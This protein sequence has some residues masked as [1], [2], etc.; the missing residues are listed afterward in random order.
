EAP[1][2]FLVTLLDR[3]NFLG[4]ILTGR[5]Q[6]GVVKV[7]QS[8]H[9]L[10]EQGNVIETG[11]ASKLMSFRGLDRVPVD[12]ARAGDIISLAGLTVATVANTIA[13]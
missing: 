3:D 10:D 9:A 6:S 2:S 11:R 12:E 4:R 5:V 1:F 8:I 7:N 13:D